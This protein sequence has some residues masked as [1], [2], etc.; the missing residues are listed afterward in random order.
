MT[1]MTKGQRVRSIQTGWTGTV[2]MGG[3][4][5]VQVAFQFA[6]TSGRKRVLKSAWR[7]ADLETVNDETST[8]DVFVVCRRCGYEH[9]ISKRC[10]NCSD[11]RGRETDV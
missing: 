1:L 4:I 9:P 3:A 7:V 2:T 11:L 8:T 5:I 10:D 6:T